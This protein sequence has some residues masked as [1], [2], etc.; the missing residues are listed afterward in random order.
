MKTEAAKIKIG[1][2]G[3]PI[4]QKEYFRHFKLVEI[5]QTFY[6]LPRL[7]TAKKWRETAPQGFEFTM[8]AWQLITHEPSSPTYRR[9]G[10]VIDPSEN[11]Y[12]GGFRCTKEILEA[13]ERTAILAYELGATHIVFQCP[14]SF[15]P[16][17][18]NIENMRKFFSR[19]D[20]GS[21]CFV[22]EPRGP[23]PD[24][25]VFELCKE[26]DLIHCVDPFKNRPQ[27][28]DI[29]YFR[30][31]GITGYSYHYTV[32]DLQNLKKW[33]LKKS[34]YLLF[35]NK[36]MKDDALRFMELMNGGA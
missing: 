31:H 27:Y 22:W 15:K 7:L 13:W 18:N 25:L 2:C 5:Q 32:P 4:A 26:F 34:T 1:C 30:L 24:K 10:K 17:E 20:R 28:G 6:K 12:Y 21:L 11:E 19:I 16:T 36:W 33:A 23:W 8:K 3:F 9:L 29:Q 35:N 14:A